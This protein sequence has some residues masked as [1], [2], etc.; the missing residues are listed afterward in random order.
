[1]DAVIFGHDKFAYELVHF[2]ANNSPKDPTDKSL[3]SLWDQAFVS[4]L[5]CLLVE[6]AV[7]HDEVER[8]CF[9]S[10]IYCWFTE[11]LLERRDVPRQEQVELEGLRLSMR[12]LAADN[13]H[14]VKA[15][16]S[17]SPDNNR[18]DPRKHLQEVLDTEGAQVSREREGRREESSRETTIIKYRVHLCKL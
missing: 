5:E 15:L 12:A 11:K 9:I 18:K 1:M 2:V 16:D 10:R 13:P 3:A 7:I 17:Y 4:G 6:C 14:T 8:D